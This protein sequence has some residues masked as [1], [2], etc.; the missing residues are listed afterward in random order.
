MHQSYFEAHVPLPA[1]PST[2]SGMSR[3]LLF[4]Q[5]KASVVPGPHRKSL[6]IKYN[7]RKAL[8]SQ[9]N[10]LSSVCHLLVLFFWQSA[11]HNKTYNELKVLP[12]CSASSSCTSYERPLKVQ[13]LTRTKPFS[14]RNGSWGMASTLV[15]EPLC[16]HSSSLSYQIISAPHGPYG[17]CSSSSAS[18][19]FA[20]LCCFSAAI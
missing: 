11:D 5:V 20:M 9:Q 2:L 19:P 3:I 14:W 4:I 13:S 8:S 7:K 18:L 12:V 1:S 15:V 17:G 6:Q 16:G 10:N